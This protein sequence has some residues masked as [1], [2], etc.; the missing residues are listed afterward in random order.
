MI[1]DADSDPNDDQKI[2]LNFENKNKND[3]VTLQNM[4]GQ[5]LISSYDN[6]Q[7]MF[8]PYDDSFGKFEIST[9]CG[10]GTSNAIK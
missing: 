7:L 8:G 6:D 9:T 3:Y 10:K 4:K 5:F 1:W 2:I